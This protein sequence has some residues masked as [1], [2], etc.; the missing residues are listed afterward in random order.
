MSRSTRPAPP[1]SSTGAAS[2][3]FRQTPEFREWVDREFPE[4]ASE[5]LSSGSRRTVLKLMA[6]SFGLAGLTACRRPV[7]HILP[8]SKGVEDYIPGQPM[9]YAT[10]A[11]TGGVATGLIVE[12][13]DGRPTKVEGNPKH[14]FSLGATNSFQQA[15]VL[16]LYDPDRAK[17]PQREGHAGDVGRVC[18]VCARAL[19]RREA[20]RWRGFADSWRSSRPRRV[21]PC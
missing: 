19:Q 9:H 15:L 2:T 6:A 7:E 20:G 4:G 12:T 18:G 3:H 8:L 5:M 11:T 10:A 13:H 14:P 17:T 16:G 21:W 1:G